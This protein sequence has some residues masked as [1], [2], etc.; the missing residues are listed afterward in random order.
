MIFGDLGALVTVETIDIGAVG[1]AVAATGVCAFEFPIVLKGDAGATLGIL[2]TL[3][4][5][6]VAALEESL[7]TRSGDAK[8]AA[9]TLLQTRCGHDAP[10][11]WSGAVVVVQDSLAILEVLITARDDTATGA[12]YLV[13]RI[14]DIGLFGAWLEGITGET[15][16]RVELTA[17][18]LRERPPPIEWSGNTR[19]VDTIDLLLRLEWM[20]ELS[21]P[22]SVDRLLRSPG[23]VRVLGP[24]GRVQL[25]KGN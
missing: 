12:G 8:A 9:E 11:E 16:N 6:V 1:G 5:N 17:S 3:N 4:R 20:E 18:V 15:E 21:T 7:L 10:V 24:S 23:R 19:S 14:A 22:T 25:L 13:R 2:D